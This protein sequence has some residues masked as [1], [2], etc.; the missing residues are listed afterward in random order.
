MTVQ[1]TTQTDISK[2]KTPPVNSW[3]NY[4]LLPHQI[5]SGKSICPKGTVIIYLTNRKHVPCLYQVIQTQ[6]EVWE[7]KKCC[8]NMSRRRV[9]PQ[10]FQVL[11]NFFECFYNLETEIET[12]FEFSFRKHRNKKGKLVNFDHQNV[13]SLCSHHHYVNSLTCQFCGS[14]ELWRND[15]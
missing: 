3:Y 5:Q 14:I 10:L 1:V 15:F 7:N 12:C 8:G 13:N 4:I 9:F 2:A 6:V 11:P